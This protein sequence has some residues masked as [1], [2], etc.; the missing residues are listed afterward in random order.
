MGGSEEIVGRVQRMVEE[1]LQGSPL[2]LVDVT[3]G[4][5]NSRNIL[6]VSIDREG[7]VNLGDCQWLSERIDLALEVEDFITSAYVLEVS[8]PGLDRPLKSRGDFQRFSGRLARITTG[9]ALDGRRK[10]LGR[11]REAGEAAVILEGEAGDSWEIPWEAIR[12][13]RL[14]A[15]F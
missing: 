14:E 3:F 12:R 11:I 8:S 5:E 1:L 2:E 13:A 9:V 15:E 6:R 10:F 4:R 7:G